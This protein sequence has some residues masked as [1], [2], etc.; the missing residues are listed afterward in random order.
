MLFSVLDA[1]AA[2]TATDTL[3]DNLIYLKRSACVTATKKHKQ[4]KPST[5]SS[6]QL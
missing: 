2:L 1:A 4:L 6:P 5:K 3:T